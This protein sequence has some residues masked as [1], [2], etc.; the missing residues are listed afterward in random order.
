MTRPKRSAFVAVGVAMLGSAGVGVA[1]L[2]RPSPDDGKHL[3]GAL[4]DASGDAGQGG[5]VVHAID[6]SGG[7]CADGGALDILIGRLDVHYGVPITGT[8]QNGEVDLVNV[9]AHISR[10]VPHPYQTGRCEVPLHRDHE[11]VT[12]AELARVRA[13]GDAG[14]AA[15]QAVAALNNPAALDDTWSFG[16]DASAEAGSAGVDSGVVV[17][18][19][20][21]GG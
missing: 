18:A 7:P 5:Y 16:F 8:K 6:E 10:R 1:V 13:L 3:F 21:Q 12:L 9:T 4:G 17:D 15:D 14:T 19:G 20:G 11:V 2:L